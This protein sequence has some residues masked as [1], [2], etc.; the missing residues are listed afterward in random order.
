MKVKM[1]DLRAFADGKMS[2]EDLI[3]KIQVEET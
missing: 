1:G 2:E 3:K